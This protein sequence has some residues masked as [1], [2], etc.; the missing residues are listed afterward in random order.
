MSTATPPAVLPAESRALNERYLRLLQDY[1]DRAIRS[2]CWMLTLWNASMLLTWVPLLLAISALA[3]G[4]PDA[5]YHARVVAILRGAGFAN[6]VVTI[7]QMVS[8]FRNRWLKYRAATE[9][10]RENC[11]RFRARLNKFCGDDAAQTFST[12]LDELEEEVSDRRPFHLWDRIPW[13]YLI[14]LQPLPGKLRVPLGHSPNKGLYPRCEEPETAYTIVIL[15]RLRNQQRW[16][17]LKARW[18]SRLYLLLQ[19]GIVLLGLTSAAY[20]WQFGDQQLATLALL[21]TAALCLIAYRERLGY[22]PLCVRYTRIVEALEQIENEYNALKEEGIAD[23][24][25][26]LERLRQTAALVERSLAS[27]FQYWYFGREN[28]GSASPC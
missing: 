18:Y 6:A 25:Q 21:T 22:A 16:H 1:D 20:R 8:L 12:A 3:Y 9:R 2:K 27:E 5:P 7:A 24:A 14:G 28:F 10:L 19:V 17:L 23:K 26:R 4:S 11:M 15:E 13:S